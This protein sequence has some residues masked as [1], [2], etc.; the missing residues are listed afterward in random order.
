M[1][2]FLVYLF[3]TASVSGCAQETSRPLPQLKRIKQAGELRVVTRYGPSTYYESINGAVGLEHDLAEL[4]AKRLDVKVRF[5][6]ADSAK[7]AIQTLD[8]GRA[9][10]AAAGL[11][12]DAVRKRKLRFA[13]PY[14]VLTE[15]IL[16]SSSRPRPATIT[17]LADGVLEVSAGSSHINTLK[18]L[19]RS[20]RNLNWQVNFDHDVHELLFLVSEGLVDYTVA[21][22]DQALIMRRY[23]PKLQVAFDIGKT[24]ELAWALPMSEDAS[25]YDETARFFREIKENRTLDQVIDR[26]Y[27]HAE[28]FDV[29]L[30]RSLRRDFR[31]RLPKFR[32]LFVQAGRQYGIDW[33]LL[34]AI[35]YQESKWHSTAVSAEGVR[36]MMMLTGVTAKQLKVTDRFDPAQSI[37]GGASYLRQTLANMP[38]EIEDPD[39]TWLALAAYNLGYGHIADARKLVAARG[40]DPDKWIEIKKVL[41]LLGKPYWY[42]KTKYGKARGRVAVHYVNSIRRYYDLLV[43]LTE[44]N[45]DGTMAMGPERSRAE[46][47]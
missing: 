31:T 7:Q 29:A 30:D 9:D 47:V 6:V 12:V 20:H 10:V 46:G 8:E 34:A 42:R 16:Y 25:L 40:G 21:N 41:P 28:A 35:A 39:R 11:L 15:Q 32:P 38:P 24:R 1:I 19:R 44:E 43:W 26:Y 4:F 2:R 14:R 13:P 18:G 17:D 5:I 22:S 3:L 36:G 33:R 27:G 45:K 37:R 23:Y